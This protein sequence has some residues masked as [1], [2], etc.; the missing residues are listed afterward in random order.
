[1]TENGRAI[2]DP[3]VDARPV[4]EI[5]VETA[6]R[7]LFHAK[8][9]PDAIQITNNPERAANDPRGPRPTEPAEAIDSAENNAQEA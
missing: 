7:A 8:A 3:R 6:R 9:F 4:T 2:N 5:T 1:M